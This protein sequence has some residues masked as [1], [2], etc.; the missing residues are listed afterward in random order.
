MKKVCFFSGDITRIGGTERV[1]ALIANALAKQGNYQILFLSLVEQEK[2]P[3]FVLEDGIERYALGTRWINPGPGYLKL[4]PRL[5]R[6]LKRHEI[7]VII[8]IDIVLDVL[9]LPAARDLGTRIISWE[10]FNYEYEME[11]LYRRYIL[12]YS[13][14]RTD[15]IITL[16]E[17]DKRAYIEKLGRDNAISTIYNP[18]QELSCEEEPEKEN[19]L[20]TV[21]RLIHRKG[22]DF[23]AEVARRVLPD[24]PNWKWLVV[25]DGEEQTFLEEFIEK[26]RLEDQLILTGRTEDVF[27]Y[28]KKAKI[29]VMTS[30]IEGLPMCLLEAKAFQ[31]PSVSFDIPTGPNEIIEDDVNGYLIKAFDCEDMAQKLNMLMK[32]DNLRKQFSEQAQNNMWKFQMESIM[33]NWNTVLEALLG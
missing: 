7:D 10:H 32:N 5:R 1:S 19:W 25:G 21:G 17:G 27:A 16:T 8:D 22:M 6:F 28:L 11:S 24:N 4:I 12:K 18:M 33:S 9:S 14:K 20:I 31:L 3:F 26:N 15:H 30:R 23:L 29:Y 13:V 2:D